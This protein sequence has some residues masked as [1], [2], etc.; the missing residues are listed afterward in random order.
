MYVFFGIFIGVGILC[1]VLNIYRRRQILCKI[2]EMNCCEKI[3]ILDEL[4]EP[5]GFSYLPDQDI[6]TSV[7]DAW[8]R[9][10]G[11]H[12]L[13]DK[14]ASRFSMVF[15]CEPIYFNYQGRTWMIEFW[16][17]QYGITT[18]GE[19]GIYC[20][21]TVLEPSEYAHTHFHSVSD[22][23]MLNLSLQLFRK[24]ELLFFVQG[25]HWWLTGFSVG[26]FFEPEELTMKV[27]VSF[28]NCDMLRKFVQALLQ[29]GYPRQS[30]FLCGLTVFFT[31]SRPYARQYRPFFRSK[32]SQWKNRL[33]CKL[34]CFVTRP[35]TFTL[36]RLLYLYYF[37]PFCF[38]RI[39]RFRK[40]RQ[41]R[42]PRR[43]GRKHV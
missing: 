4:L 42:F 5:F 21:D 16:K 33:F 8:Q 1:S 36:D 41:Q 35:F 9:E 24:G 26:R 43:H 32:L 17:G 30:L 18:G 10:F 39:L 40:C 38:R 15:D 3:C 25:L 27:S 20:A 34:F 13:F 2:R 12:A 22:E 19:I 14:S 29:A 6:I 31:F 37:L 28:P 23:Q 11:Y 7:Q